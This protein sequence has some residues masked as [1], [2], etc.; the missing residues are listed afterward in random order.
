MWGPREGR[1]PVGCPGDQVMGFWR[2][3]ALSADPGDPCLRDDY[4]G[5]SASA[6]APELFSSDWEIGII[7]WFVHFISGITTLWEQ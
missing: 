6:V 3:T 2:D 7:M 5:V 1:E 4:P